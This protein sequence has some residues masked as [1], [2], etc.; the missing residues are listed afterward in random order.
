MDEHGKIHADN[1]APGQKV[2]VAGKVPSDLYIPPG[3][4]HDD[5][6][7]KYESYFGMIK[8]VLIDLSGTL[9]IE[10]QETPSA[11]KALEK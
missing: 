6:G 7:R 4:D 2:V 9:H 3:S 5:I 11:I 10:N 1:L 8:Y